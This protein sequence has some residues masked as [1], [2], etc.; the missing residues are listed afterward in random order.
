M[1]MK[2]FLFKITLTGLLLCS[3]V[4]G[5]NKI[6][7]LMDQSDSV[8]V[9]KFDNVPNDI[10]ICNVGSSH[11]LYGFCYD[12]EDKYNC[13]NFALVSQLYTYDSRILEYY[14]GHLSNDCV[15]FIPVSYFSFYGKPENQG[16]DFESKNQRYYKFLPKELITDYSEKTKFLTKF[17]V[18]TAYENLARI[19]L[20]RNTNRTDNWDSQTADS[21][22]LEAYVKAVYERHIIK[23]KIDADGKRIIS[24]ES[25]DSL[26]ALVETCKNAGAR[27]VLVTMPFMK[28][29]TDEIAINSPEFYEEFQGLLESIVKETGI[30]YYD[31]SHDP[32]FEES[33][34]LFMNGDHLNRAGATLFTDIIIKEVVGKTDK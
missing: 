21:I 34:D 14:K 1:K 8:Y 26:Y 22:D 9:K 17:P 16:E 5:L 29:Y 11:G 15:V 18:L 7:I 27:P 12:N 31:Y 24:E 33:H 19:F 25:I 32:R 4:V 23:N 10:N 13:F 20:T 28:E 3:I 30:E 2:S 6:Y